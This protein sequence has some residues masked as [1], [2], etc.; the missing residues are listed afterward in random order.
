MEPE[1]SLQRAVICGVEVLYSA[2]VSDGAP[3]ES[4]RLWPLTERLARFL[5]DTYPPKDGLQGRTVLELGAGTAAL[6]AFVA[7]AYPHAACVATDLPAVLPT[8]RATVAANHGGNSILQAKALAWGA[9]MATVTPAGVHLVL[10]C[11]CLYWGGWS[12]LHDDT[13]GPLLQTLR[14]V[15]AGTAL[16]LAFTVRD[17]DRE[18]TFLR[19]LLRLYVECGC[20]PGTT[21]WQSAREGDEIVLH[22]R[23][24]DDDER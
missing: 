7:K 17:A 9:S 3:A 5:L 18:I 10:C 12:L 19:D 1:V 15:P 23:R 21:P 13:R 16:L 4:A 2:A 20:A 8:M 11:E 14:D 24:N 6:S 22:L